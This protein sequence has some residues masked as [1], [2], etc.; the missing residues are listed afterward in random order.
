MASETNKQSNYTCTDYRS[1]MILLGLVRRLRAAAPGS[2]Q[3]EDLRRQIKTLK[4]EM[5]MD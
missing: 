2:R 5:G 3:A 1:E 4:A